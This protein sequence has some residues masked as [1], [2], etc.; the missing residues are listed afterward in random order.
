MNPESHTKNFLGSYYL[1]THYFKFITVCY[2]LIY[3][4]FSKNLSFCHFIK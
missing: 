4:F 2:Y 3:L 1:R